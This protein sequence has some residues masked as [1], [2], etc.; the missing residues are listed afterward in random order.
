M[1][2]NNIAFLELNKSLDKVLKVHEQ[3][4]N[5]YIRCIVAL[6]QAAAKAAK[7]RTTKARM[8]ASDSRA[9]G[10]ILSRIRKNNTQYKNLISDYAKNPELFEDEDEEDEEVEEERPQRVAP[11]KPALATAA[12]AATERASRW[13][14]KDADSSDEDDDDLDDSDDMDD[15][16]DSDDDFDTDED[17]SDDDKIVSKPDAKRNFWLKS[18]ETEVKQQRGRKTRKGVGK[19]TTQ[20]RVR[21][22]R[23]LPQPKKKMLEEMDWTADLIEENIIKI[24]QNK[25]KRG[26]D[27]QEQYDLLKI[28]FQ[29]SEI[30]SKQIEILLLMI[31][32][33]FDIGTSHFMPAEIWNNSYLNMLRILHIID[34]LPDDVNIIEQEETL[35]LLAAAT[36]AEAEPMKKDDVNTL[37]ITGNIVTIF[38]R[39]DEEFIKSLQ[40][41]DPHMQKYVQRLNDECMLMDMSERLFILYSSKGDMEKAARIAVRIFGHIYYKVRLLFFTHA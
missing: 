29:N 34:Q 28:L 10:P 41:T 1:K 25:G 12:G 4:P 26:V 39:L 24:R 19:A 5:M 20:R 23:Q 17:E 2:K 31:S 38:E 16:D 14:K 3:V 13:F 37:R 18:S 9:L 8:T 6:E 36:A 27:P 22:E 32:I 21:A 30:P 15:F 11:S 40:Y 33:S 35:P 7:D